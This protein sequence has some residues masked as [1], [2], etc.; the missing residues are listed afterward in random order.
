M[1]AYLVLCMM[2]H[3]SVHMY[4]S[5]LWLD[6]NLTYQAD[7][8]EDCALHGAAPRVR[9]WSVRTRWRINVLVNVIFARFC[10]RFKIRTRVIFNKSNMLGGVFKWWLMVGLFGVDAAKFAD[11]PSVQPA[12]AHLTKLR[13]GATQDKKAE[14]IKTAEQT[15]TGKVWVTSSFTRDHVR[16]AWELQREER[17]LDTRGGHDG[18]VHGD[19]EHGCVAARAGPAAVIHVL[20]DAR[21]HL[22]VRVEVGADVQRANLCETRGMGRARGGGGQ[23]GGK[24]LRF[25]GA[26]VCSA[27]GHARLSATLCPSASPAHQTCPS[28]WSR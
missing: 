25:S 26:C 6:L 17:R 15:K 14:Q 21:R 1:H 19:A 2:V 22:A 24:G 7:L 9:W 28:D 20:V 16:F 12:F 23:A 4:G 3:G 13:G 11:R 18:A 27:Q 5:Q 8:R 10:A